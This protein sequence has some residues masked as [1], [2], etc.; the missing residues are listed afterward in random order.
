M[1]LF[2]ILCAGTSSRMGGAN[3]L[4]LPLGDKTVLEHTLSNILASGIAQVCAVTGHE[5]EKIT[6]VLHNYEVA[7]VYNPDFQ[8]GMTT[9][10]QAGIKAA[11]MNATGY[12]ICP[13]DMPFLSASLIQQMI[14]LFEAQEGKACIIAPAFQ[15]KRGHPVLF[16]LHFRDAILSHRDPDGCKA[17]IQQHWQQLL[18]FEAGDDGVIR[19]IDTPEA[20][21]AAIEKIK[22]NGR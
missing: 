19:D 16:S 21:A 15:G 22:T 1:L 20:Y 10:I 18:T 2:I 13:G 12:F 5:Q 6:A 9:S 14:R 7:V 11:G 17:I 3:K 8:T 4:L